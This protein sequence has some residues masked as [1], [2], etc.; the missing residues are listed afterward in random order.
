MHTDSLGQLID[1]LIIAQLKVWHYRQDQ[2]EEAAQVEGEQAEGLAAAIETYLWECLSGR[3]VPLIQHHLRYHDHNRTEAWRPGKKAT[4]MIPES[5]SGCILRLVET[6][7]G[8][9]RAQSRIQALKKLIDTAP[10]I[11]EKHHFEQ[12]FIKLQRQEI[13][14]ANQQR[15]ETITQLDHLF[16]AYHDARKGSA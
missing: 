4:E 14:L 11:T 2:K 15:N 16:A 8:Y 5:I 12:E 6:H 9:W 1:R 10:S 3:R 7:A 13:D